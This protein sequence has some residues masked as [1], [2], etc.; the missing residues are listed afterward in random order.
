MARPKKYQNEAARLE[1]RRLSKRKYRAKKCLSRENKALE[2]EVDGFG[3]GNIELEETPSKLSKEERMASFD[4]NINELSNVDTSHEI[5]TF[6]F[7][8]PKKYR[9]RRQTRF[10]KIIQQF[11]AERDYANKYAIRYNL[12]DRWQSLPLD[13]K[14]TLN[15]VSQLDKEGF[16]DQKTQQEY[17]KD[18]N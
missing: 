12:G 14:T 11:L 16:L 7:D 2:T 18:G 3:F 6:N 10:G 13:D 8:V 15:F 4:K 5:F 17:N 1:A 9:H